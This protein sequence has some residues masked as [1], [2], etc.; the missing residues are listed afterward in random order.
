MPCICQFFGIVIYMYFN[1]HSPPHFH[2]RYSGHEA[3]YEIDSL[4]I[5]RGGLPRRAHNLVIEW[6]DLHRA[7]FDRRLASREGRLRSE[8]DRTFGL[9]S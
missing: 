4:R 6:A 8:T 2:A 3:L 9:T 5:Y 1:D 7:E